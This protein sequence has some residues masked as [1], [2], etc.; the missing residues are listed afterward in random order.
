MKKFWVLLLTVALLLL[1]AAACGRGGDDNGEDEAQPTPTPA[2]EQQDGGTEDTTDPGGDPVDDRPLMPELFGW[3]SRYF[4]NHG[5][6][7]T[8]MT[9]TANIPDGMMRYPGPLGNISCF[10]IRDATGITIDFQPSNDERFALMAAVGDLPDIIIFDTG[11]ARLIGDMITA[12]LLLDMGPLMPRYAPGLDAILQDTQKWVR[13]WVREN[14]ESD[15]VYFLPT[16]VI[17]I[18]D[19]EILTTHGSTMGFNVRMDIYRAIGAPPIYNEHGFCEGLF[20]D[21]LLQ[22]QNYA[23]YE[24]GY[25]NA[26]ALS[27]FNEWG[28]LWMTVLG[29]HYGISGQRGDTRY[30]CLHTGEPF[31]PFHDPAHY[32]W[33]A[34]RFLNRAYRMGIWNPESF[35]LPWGEFEHRVHTGDVLAPMAPW[36]IM[37]NTTLPEVHP[38]GGGLQDGQPGGAYVMRG[39][40]FNMDIIMANNTVGAGIHNARAINANFPYPER[41]MALFDFTGSD[42]FIRDSDRVHGLYGVHWQYDANGYPEFIGARLGQ[43]LGIQE[44]VDLFV[45]GGHY[46]FGMYGPISGVY[47]RMHRDGFP[48][49]FRLAE[50]WIEQYMTPG[51]PTSLFLQ[52]YN[53]PPHYRMPSQVY[54][55]WV[56]EGILRT[57]PP[58]NLAGHFVPGQPDDMAAIAGRVEVFIQENEAALILAP[59]EEAF[60]AELARVTAAIYDMGEGAVHA[61][62]LARAAEAERIAAEVLGR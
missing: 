36:M 61:D 15:G 39:M 43:H 54:M 59:T 19:A 42:E 2:Q 16:N 10:M 18:G 33:D 26:Y 23:R 55:Q 60:E 21:M 45:P 29:Y 53:A 6:P 8:P 51:L 62:A 11:D 37:W 7:L 57:S 14:S 41:L 31:P 22:L 35:V 4:D 47:N 12:G 32:R 56:R 38:E 24:M 58:F 27:G 25:P 13:H 49:N 50:Y 48:L 30:T 34:Y 52:M 20:L 3:R 46:D 1:M 9:V 44:Y 17:N 40:P 5:L 28:H